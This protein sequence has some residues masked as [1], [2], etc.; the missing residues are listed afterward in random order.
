MKVTIVTSCVCD[1]NI[2]NAGIILLKSFLKSEGIDFDVFDLS[3]TLDYFS[4]PKEIYS[5]CNDPLWGKIDAITTQNWIAKYIKHLPDGETILF[6][7][8]FSLD[9]VVHT[10]IA[11]K[12][13]E[14]NKDIKCICGGSSLF[15]LPTKVLA[16][17]NKVF[18][19]ICVGND[20]TMLREALV[21]SNKAIKRSF[22][23]PNFKIQYDECDLKKYVNLFSGY[24]CYWKNCNF[25]DFTP[26]D[27]PMYIRPAEQVVKDMINIYE[28]NPNVERIFLTIDTYDY[29]TLKLITDLLKT[30]K[31]EIPYG[32]M[33]RA[34]KWISEELIDSLVSTGCCD[35]FIGVEALDN[36]LLDTLNKGI[37]VDQIF[38]SIKTISKYVQ[39]HIGMISFIPRAT[40]GQLD[41]QYNNLIQLAPYIGSIEYEILSVTHSSTFSSKNKEY[42]IKLNA[43]NKIINNSWC[44]GF[45][46]DEPWTFQDESLFDL[47][48]PHSISVLDT[49]GAKIRPEY[50]NAI[51]ALLDRIN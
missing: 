14:Q 13:K 15:S 20:L 37:T 35:I 28:L 30:H 12:L 2:T 34:E 51:A 39:P 23:P 33:L 50:H 43:T 27:I 45:S 36:H 21:N 44:Y 41:N 42:G 7:S 24:G 47:W 3:G 11:S 49:V 46:N 26:R 31:K 1:K 9:L 48:V 10:W 17:L 29:K 5:F 8:P 18:D 16:E 22:A 19:I 25:C 32:I 6:S 38:T 40:K 4:P